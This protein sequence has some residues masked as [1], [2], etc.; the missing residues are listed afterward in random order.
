[1]TFYPYRF[2]TI[3]NTALFIKQKRV[4]GE[5][6]I[7]H[8]EQLQGF[9]GQLLALKEQLLITQDWAKSGTQPVELD[10]ARV[11]RLSRVDALQAQAMS[12]ASSHRRDIQLQRIESALS[13]IEKDEYGICTSCGED[14]DLKRL[15][16]D[17]TAFLCIDCARRSE[18]SI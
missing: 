12:V 1:V 9:R 16:F 3:D 18:R 8:P 5:W 4:D 7:M 11:G 6:T 14:I 2:T 10:Q 13:R 17:P 15:Q